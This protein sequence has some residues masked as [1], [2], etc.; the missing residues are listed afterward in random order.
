M[1]DVN[2]SSR[3]PRVLAW[4]LLLFVFAAGLRVGWVAVRYH[5]P[6]RTEW[7]EYPDEEAYWL[8]ARSLSAGEG[9][10]DEFGYQATYMPA[11]PMFLSMFAGLE[12]PLWWARIVQAL[13]AAWVAPATFLLA[14]SWARWSAASDEGGIPRPAVWAGLAAALDPFLVFFSGLLLT[15]ALFAA[16]LTSAWVLV[17]AISAGLSVGP[18]TYAPTRASSSSAFSGAGLTGLAIG[19]GLLLWLGVMLRPSAVMLVAATAALLLAGRRAIRQR[20]QAAAIVVVVVIIALLPWAL[21]NRVVLGQWRWLTTR[22]GISLYDGLQPGA[23][24]GSDLAHT[25]TLPEMRGL[26]EIA[27]DRYFRDQAWAAVRQDPARAIGLAW[28]KFLRTWSLGPNVA[29]YRHGLPAVVSA[30]WT[31]SLLVLAIV[32]LWSRRR[33]AAA[34][35]TILLPVIVFTLLHMVFIGSV[36]YRVPVMPMVMVLSAAGLHCLPQGRSRSKPG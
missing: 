23:T 32:G 10:R 36:R 1:S 31:A 28:N 8:A 2:H 7:L 3:S 13:L 12:H 34:C 19:A 27:W 11:Y 5:D 33:S 26:S 22:G 35:V 4:V 24:G 14:G 25:K 16:A 18:T 30:G 29:A 20:W 17:V 6:S 9:L 15:E 21:R